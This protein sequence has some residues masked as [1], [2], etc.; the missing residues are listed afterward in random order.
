MIIGTC[1]IVL[2]LPAAGSLKEKRSVVKSILARV[3]NEFNV[4]IAE[5]DYQDVCQQAVLG[6]ACVSTSQNHAHSQIEAVVRFIE[7]RR[8]DLP[9]VSYEIEML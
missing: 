1:T 4:A 3:H 2:Y 9:L 8:P 7:R 6:L 5:V